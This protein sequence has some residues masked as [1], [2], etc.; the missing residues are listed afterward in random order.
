MWF[1]WLAMGFCVGLVC[2]A[3]YSVFVKQ[4]LADAQAELEYLK[5]KYL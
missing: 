1:F 3:I 2:G 4:K 5:Q